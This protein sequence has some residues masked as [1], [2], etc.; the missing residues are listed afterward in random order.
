SFVLISAV[1]LTATA[2]LADESATSESKTEYKNNGGYE[3]TS[4]S[5]ETTPEGTSKTSK[6]TVD[7]DVDRNGLASKDIKTKTTTDPEGLFN[8]KTSSSEDRTKQKAN[9]GY[10]RTT[11]HEKTD[12]AGTN[13]SSKTKTD[14]DVDAG[15]NTVATTKSQQTVDPKGLMNKHTTTSETK[16]VNGTVVEENQESK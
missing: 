5:E 15:G 3:S 14:V 1:M 16:S 12:A 9:G 11:T 10:T 8:K 2:A 13:I 6:T 7:V 4:S